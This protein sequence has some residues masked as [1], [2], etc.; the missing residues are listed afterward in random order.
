MLP[1]CSASRGLHAGMEWGCRVILFTMTKDALLD[2]YVVDH[3]L[4]ASQTSCLVSMVGLLRALFSEPLQAGCSCGRTAWRN[5][6]L[7][8]SASK[9]HDLPHG[10]AAPA[11]D[12]SSLPAVGA[13]AK[14]NHSL[15]YALSTVWNTGWLSMVFDILCGGSTCNDSGVPVSKHSVGG[16]TTFLPPLFATLANRLKTIH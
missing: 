2:L 16:G 5:Q 9:M 1:K 10:F 4:R 12:L 3:K 6:G 11:N 15:V 13:V 7:N 14:V 8:L